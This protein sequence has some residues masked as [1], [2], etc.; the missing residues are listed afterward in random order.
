MYGFFF[1]WFEQRS[2]EELS[3]KGIYIY[4]FV[5]KRTPTNAP[6]ASVSAGAG[7]VVLS[8]QHDHL[9]PCYDA[10]S[11]LAALGKFLTCTRSWQSREHDPQSMVRSRALMCQ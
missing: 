3:G 5:D 7:V 4:I 11:L 10:C 6:G 1:R 8:I 2:P 9:S